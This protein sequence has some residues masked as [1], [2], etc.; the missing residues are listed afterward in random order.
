MR[1]ELN[2]LHTANQPLLLREKL[3]YQTLL[4]RNQLKISQRIL[5]K[6]EQISSTLSINWKIYFPH[7]YDNLHQTK[8]LPKE[9]II[10]SYRKNN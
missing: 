9:T 2:N 6:I 4:R 1:D 7:F 10:L 5:S 8:I 3:V